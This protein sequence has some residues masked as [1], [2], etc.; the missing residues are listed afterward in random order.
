MKKLIITIAVALL[1]SACGFHLRGIIDVPE[2]LT[3]ISIISNDVNNKQLASLLKSQL[4]G[5]KIHVNPDPALAQY[6]LII[7]RS[8]YQQQIISIG[9]STNPRQYQLILTVDFML[10][11][12]KG[13]IIKPKRQITVSRQLTVNNDRILGSNEEETILIREMQQDA[14][15]QIINRLSRNDSTMRLHP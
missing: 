9:A 3:N 14:V 2:W 8:N 15:I 7:D 13:Q 1:I 12:R 5:Y 11:D 10:Q 6:W 4:E